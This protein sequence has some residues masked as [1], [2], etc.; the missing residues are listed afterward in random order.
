M[1]RDRVEE[2]KKETIFRAARKAKK[3]DFETKEQAIFELGEIFGELNRDLTRE[4]NRE[5][6]KE[7]VMKDRRPHLTTVSSS[8]AENTGEI[9]GEI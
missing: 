2:I 4:L 9:G 8:S 7:F 3:I 1:T 6:A 5:V